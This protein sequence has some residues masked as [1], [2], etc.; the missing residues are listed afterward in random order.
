MDIITPSSGVVTG[1]IPVAGAIK[2]RSALAVDLIFIP[3]SPSNLLCEQ[4]KAESGS[5]HRLAVF[6]EDLVG[7]G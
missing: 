1:S 6:R 7:R 2:I 5:N 3:S 4:S